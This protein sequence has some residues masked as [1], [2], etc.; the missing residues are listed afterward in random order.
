MFIAALFTVPQKAEVTQ[1][2][3]RINMVRYCFYEVPTVVPFREAG[4]RVV[5]AWS[6]GGWQEWGDE[7]SRGQSFSWGWRESSADDYTIWICFMSLNWTLKMIKMVNFMLGIFHP[8]HTTVLRVHNAGQSW[9]PLFNSWKVFYEVKNLAF[10][11]MLTK[12]KNTP[13]QSKWAGSWFP[14]RTRVAEPT[15]LL[16]AALSSLASRCVWA[17]EEGGLVSGWWDYEPSFPS[18]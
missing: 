7:T 12:I 9:R 5:V 11:K 15:L 1:V 16:W 10:L 2:F 13:T 14:C 8:T 18:L 4:R 3:K 6:L 17:L